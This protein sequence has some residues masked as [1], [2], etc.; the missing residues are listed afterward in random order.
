MKK[1]FQQPLKNLRKKTIGGSLTVLEQQ[2]QEKKTS[3]C[4]QCTR[5][6]SVKIHY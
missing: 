1:T 5:I 4:S 2:K 3:V 6:N